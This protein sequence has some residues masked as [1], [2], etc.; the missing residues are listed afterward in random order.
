MERKIICLLLAQAMF[1]LSTAYLLPIIYLLSEIE[2]QKI[3]IAFATFLIISL[4]MAIIL[5]Y[6]SQGH[7]QRIKVKESATSMILI[8]LLLAMFGSFPF[9]AS[10]QLKPIEALLETVSDFT[11]AGIGILPASSPYVLK[12]WQSEL[13]WIGSLIY[14]NILVTVMPEVSGC[15]GL[16][17]SLSQGQIFSPMLGQMKFMARKVTIIYILLT[18]VSYV[19]FRL[20]GLNM[21]DSIQMSM[22]CISTGGGNYFAGRGSIYVEYAAMTSML[23]A[24]GNLLLYHRLL[25]TI[26]PPTSSLNLM[27]PIKIKNF[28]KSIHNLIDDFISLVK[29]NTISNLKI[30]SSNSEVQFLFISMTIGTIL[31]AFTTFNEYYLTD[32]NVS[33]RRAMFHVISFISTT[34][35]STVNLKDIPDYD[36]FFL[37]LMAAVGG[38]IG[39][40]TGGLKIIR[41]II[42]FK[43]AKMET[44]K[45][46]HPRMI[47]NIKVNKTAVSL[48]ISGRILSFFF[49]SLLTLF[50]F[51]IILSL[52]G[53]TFSTSVAMSFACL[54]T[55][56]NLPGICDPSTFME[57]PAIMKIF[58]C[59]IFIVG[60]MEI[61]AF[62]IFV[63]TIFNRNKR[64]KF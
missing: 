50:M 55:I 10:F 26:K 49:L 35:V 38:C 3:L 1:A 31:I 13:M 23:L 4:F 2:N 46:I 30:F 15:F 22:K 8:W 36:K 25:L 34:G 39:S 20:A 12:L 47:T 11:S 43:L 5:K 19:L 33:F 18:F 45:V 61:F 32:G 58:C 57:L 7:K 40:V 24:C 54:T 21:W 59:L 64:Q 29:E 14:L 42:L 17:L 16:E 56:G 63:N 48:K 28:A 62:L 27:T 44:L 6:K 53:Q 9:I 60:R 41:V 37:F 51:A 52:S